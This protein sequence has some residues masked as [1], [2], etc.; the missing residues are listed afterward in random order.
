MD[1]IIDLFE[2]SCNK[3]PDNPY[4][5]EKVEG[6]YV[7]RTYADARKRVCGIAGG[8]L[9]AGLKKGQRVALLSEGC[10]DWVC[11]EL[12]ILYAGG[13]HVPLSIRLT[14]QELIF[15]LNHSGCRFLIVSAY[16]KHTVDRIRNKLE[17]IERIYVFSR[18][19][20]DDKIYVPFEILVG[21]GKKWLENNYDRFCDVFS[22]VQ[23]G[24]V[25][26]ITYTSGTTAE[27]KGIMLT[28]ANYVCN[29]LQ[30]DF[31]IQIP[32]YFRI[33]L[34]LP[35]DHSFAHTVGIYSFMYN[36]ASIA[37]V[38]FGHS[39]MEC[40]RNIPVNMKEIR[41]HVLLSVPAIAKNFR[42]NIEAEIKKK[43][44][45]IKA[46]Y[47]RGLKLAYW[48]Y[49]EGRMEPKGGKKLIYPLLRFFDIFVFKK[50]RA[51]FG[52]HLR[53]FVG[54]GALLDVELQKYFSALGIPMYQGYGLSEASPVISSNTPDKHKFGSSGLPVSPMSLKI[55]DENGKEVNTGEQGEIVIAGGN[56]M[57]G[58]WRNEESTEEAVREGW[59][60]T[61]DLG[62][63]DKSGFLYV[64]GR[65]KSLL[66]ANDGEK[67]SPEGIEEAIVEKSPYIEACM[68]YNNQSLYTSALIVPNKQALKEYV[69]RKK[70]EWGSVEGYKLMLMKINKELMEFR[71][72]GKY[73]GLFPERWLPAVVAILPRAFKESDGTINSSAKMVRRR[74]VELYREELEYVYTPEGKDIQNMRNTQNI[75]KLFKE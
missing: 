50:I 12:G 52:G 37:A 13:I 61:G 3:F 15:R 45:I 65:F 31:L 57:K 24:H 49:G 54:G 16:Y 26:N 51:T 30:A 41:P 7:A 20:E 73:E 42:K 35:W 68:L 25:A 71:H 14:D 44:Y 40:L 48:Y 10:A 22:S 23:P 34:F 27:P 55:L 18:D 47:N 9:S 72:G 69:E 70:E 62:Y 59:L 28:H 1:T 2:R 6:K 56:V 32:E 64:L 33:L 75:R 60:Y 4:L 21:K 46:A 5:W 11:C 43:G 67:Y 66:I 36:G 17:T 38:D 63:I 19:T 74:I 58:Y 53:F 39:P 29:V 8:L